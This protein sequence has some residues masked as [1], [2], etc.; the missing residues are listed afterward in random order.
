MMTTLNRIK[1]YCNS[2]YYMQP[3]GTWKKGGDG[4][5]KGL[6][7]E[8]LPKD[9][10]ISNFAH[11]VG[12]AESE[13]ALNGINYDQA[14]GLG[15]VPDN[16]NVV[17]KGFAVE[18]PVKKF[19]KLAA[20]RDFKD[21]STS[22]V[23]AIQE[24]IASGQPI[25]SPWLDVDFNSGKIPKVTRHEGRTR[26]EAI[27]RINGDG[28]TVLVHI[29]GALGLRSRDITPQMVAN[30]RAKVYAEKSKKIVTDLFESDV[31][32]HG[33]R[34][35]VQLVESKALDTDVAS[36]IEARLPVIINN[37]RWKT[38]LRVFIEDRGLKKIGS[39]VYG[40]VFEIPND[41]KHVLKIFSDRAYL[42]W[43]QLCQTKLKGNPYVPVFK[44]KPVKLYKNQD[45]WAIRLEKLVSYDSSGIMSFY[46]RALLG[47]YIN[48]VLKNKVVEIKRP[49]RQFLKQLSAKFKFD[50]DF[51]NLQKALADY[52]SIGDNYKHFFLDVH[53][54]NM[55]QRD[56][57]PWGFVIVDPLAPVLKH[58]FGKP[59]TQDTDIASLIEARMPAIKGNSWKMAMRKIA[60]DHGLKWMG[61]GAFGSVFSIPSNPEY[62]LK[63]FSD[64]SYLR[65][66]Q[67]CQTSLRGNKYAP[68]FKGKPVKLYPDRNLWGIRIKR[69]L[70]IDR[71][72]TN[73]TDF[74]N[75]LNFYLVYLVTHSL[76]LDPDYFN[77]KDVDKRFKEVSDKY[78]DDEDFW[79]LTST[80]SFYLAL[81]ENYKHFTLDLHYNNVMVDPNTKGYVV[82]DPLAQSES[83][84]KPFKFKYGK[85]EI[86]DTEVP[87]S[88][89]LRIEDVNSLL[90]KKGYRV[91]N[92][93]PDEIVYT[94]SKIG[95][96]RNIRVALKNKIV[97][98]ITVEI[99][100]PNPNDS[101][102]PIVIR[103][104]VN[105]ESIRNEAGT[106][107]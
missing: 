53:Q 95:K 81:G 65:W 101:W 37:K 15:A 36:L 56:N 100:S 33:K 25:A 50:N 23:G 7:K 102:N 58:K 40:Y 94:K 91:D 90:L 84:A 43:V 60:E 14:N 42:R 41:P 39:G 103:R 64:R 44:G 24:I 38:A 17:Y 59:T 73:G 106:T 66:V 70:P 19:L 82:V 80:L 48:K 46:I 20:F 54:N 57:D 32:L 12:D 78:E 8:E 63:V 5:S 35:T 18:M 85:P 1:A 9:A 55:M 2:L 67:L 105:L 96:R 51:I 77:R 68:Q 34:T 107:D 45:L 76:Q 22:N 28:A 89:N 6:R 71:L 29:F 4:R 3:D 47:N 74:V 72:K 26:C 11:F 97:T 92:G 30:F 21:D 13:G 86:P 98:D 27:R 10:V 83:L 52:L 87:S 49:D 93:S 104:K 16:T 88:M 61:S 79:D 62:V 31:W 75:D 69:L 99:Q